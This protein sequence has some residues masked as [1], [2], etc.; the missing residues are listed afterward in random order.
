MDR[1]TQALLKAMSRGVT[2]QLSQRPGSRDIR[3]RATVVIDGHTYV[4]DTLL[5]ANISD[6][7]SQHGN[8]I[9]NQLADMVNMAEDYIRDRRS[10]MR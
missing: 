8:P 10:E 5:P 7:A 6:S 2:V 1:L 9:E 4:D 3:L